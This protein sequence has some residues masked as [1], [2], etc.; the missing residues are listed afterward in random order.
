MSERHLTLAEVAERLRVSRWT[1]RRRLKE[2]PEIRPISTGRSVVFDRA[3]ISALEDALRCPSGCTSPE[4][5]KETG[6]GSPESR[7]MDDALRSLRR[8]QT[9]RLLNAGRASSSED[10]DKIVLL[11]RVRR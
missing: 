3:T 1:I 9:K 2:H 10:C 7:S 11:D 8:Q 4:A 6:S 5:E